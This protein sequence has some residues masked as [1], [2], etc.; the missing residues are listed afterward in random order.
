LENPVVR[1][2]IL[3]KTVRKS[4]QNDLKISNNP[5]KGKGL[6]AGAALLSFESKNQVDRKWIS[7]K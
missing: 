6:T 7:G 1:N 3:K 4:R 5:I 2:R